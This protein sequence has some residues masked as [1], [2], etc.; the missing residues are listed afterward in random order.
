MEEEFEGLGLGGNKR[1]KK[2]KS[3]VSSSDSK[4][5]EEKVLEKPAEM[6]SKAEEAKQEPV[7][8]LE[9]KDDEGDGLGLGLSGAKKRNRKKKPGTVAL[10]TSEGL[11]TST[12]DVGIASSGSTA[13]PV[14]SASAAVPIPSVPIST[15]QIRPT[16]EP[17]AS[18][19]PWGQGFGRGVGRGQQQIK[20]QTAVAEPQQPIITPK[21]SAPE[22]PSPAFQP[23]PVPMQPGYGRGVGRG[24]SP[25]IS[26]PGPAQLPVTTPQLRQQ[27]GQQ[28]SPKE[29]PKQYGK[30]VTVCGFTVPSKIEGRSVR[31]RQ[32]KVLTNYLAMRFTKV[33]KIVS[34]L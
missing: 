34:R 33:L 7:E 1:K 16:N 5:V 29:L 27:P 28:V 3:Q 23:D 31:Y 21:F 15:Q 32:A 19:L 25:V 8:K 14:P 10:K 17:A 2:S 18:Q 30:E 9:T 20:P 12:S 26:T 6:P 11:V 4:V 22:I 13:V 24:K